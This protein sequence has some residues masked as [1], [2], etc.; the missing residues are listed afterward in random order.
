MAPTEFVVEGKPDLV[1]SCLNLAEPNQL[2]SEPGLDAA[3]TSPHLAEVTPH[4]LLEGSELECNGS[5]VFSSHDLET[6]YKLQQ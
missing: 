4:L 2:L 6:T 3:K 1:D 5:E